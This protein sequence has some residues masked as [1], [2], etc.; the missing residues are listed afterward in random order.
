MNRT[1]RLYAIVE[2]LRAIAPRA[3]TARELAA[4]HEVSV[5]TI[6]RD[7]SALQQ[8]GVP[9]YASP[10]RRGGYALDRSMALPPVNFTPEE[11]VAVAVALSAERT[12]FVAEARSALRK[13]LAA[14]P[15][16]GRDMA[17]D[18]AGRVAVVKPPEERAPNPVLRVVEDAVIHRRVLR[19]EY[20]DAAGA[21]TRRVV[22][23]VVLLGGAAGRW[24]LVAWCRLRRDSRA[25]RL[26]RVISAHPTGETAPDHPARGF[27]SDLPPSVVGANAFD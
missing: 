11:A 2:E 27:R 7:L 23:P 5:R 21:L 24:Y 9:I 4:R 14:M 8:A 17:R 19:I 6:E 10:G 25:F 26:D 13:L 18:M 20:G 22:E 16:S 1:D 12:P 15:R 3:R